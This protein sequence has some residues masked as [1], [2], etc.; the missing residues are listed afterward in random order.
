LAGIILFASGAIIDAVDASAAVSAPGR[1][2]LAPVVLDEAT[3]DRATDQPDTPVEALSKAEEAS[4]S[5]E[6][7]LIVT[8]V[9]IG[10][11]LLL[12]AAFWT[13]NTGAGGS[14]GDNARVE[15]NADTLADNME[16]QADN[17]D[18]IADT[19]GTT[20]EVPPAPA[21]TVEA[22]PAATTVDEPALEDEG[23]QGNEIDS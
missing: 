17:L 9:V 4:G 5:P 1:E 8:V 7:Q 20:I 10:L 14:S 13:R 19:T 3:T 15:L 23:Y 22:K 21:A 11:V 6:Y 12:L 2:S 16:A 18:A